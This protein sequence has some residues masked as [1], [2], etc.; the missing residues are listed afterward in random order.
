MRVGGDKSSFFILRSACSVRTQGIEEAHYRLQ[1]DFSFHKHQN[2]WLMNIHHISEIHFERVVTGTSAIS[3]EHSHWWHKR[4]AQSSHRGQRGKTI[5]A[6]RYNS[7][8]GS[9][10]KKS[11]GDRLYER[12]WTSE[13]YTPFQGNRQGYR[14]GRSLSRMRKKTWLKELP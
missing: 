2:V 13:T 9:A 6:R 8:L 7:G 11:G 4:K 3:N 10:F 5:I 14:S 12:K 1:G